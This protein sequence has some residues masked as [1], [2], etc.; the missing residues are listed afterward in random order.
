MLTGNFKR[1]KSQVAEDIMAPVVYM[2]F[3][4]NVLLPQFLLVLVVLLLVYTFFV[5]VQVY[6]STVLFFEYFV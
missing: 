4:Y 6:R 1:K 5:V 2:T 3:S